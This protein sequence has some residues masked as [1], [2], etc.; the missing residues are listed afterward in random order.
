MKKKL[1]KYIITGIQ[2]LLSIFLCLTLLLATLKVI[3]G[4]HVHRFKPDLM[5]LNPKDWG[6]YVLDVSTPYG[7]FSAKKVYWNNQ[8]LTMKKVRFHTSLSIASLLPLELQNISITFTPDVSASA[9]WGQHHFQA[10]K[11]NPNDD[12]KT[13]ALHIDDQNYLLK[14][15]RDQIEL[16]QE[17]KQAPMLSLKKEGA[18]YDGFLDL[19]FLDGFQGR[20]HWRSDALSKNLYADSIISPACSLQ[21]GRIQQLKYMDLSWHLALNRLKCIDLVDIKTVKG[22][23]SEAMTELHVHSNLGNLHTQTD[24]SGQWHETEPSQ[25]HIESLPKPCL[26]HIDGHRLCLFPD[27]EHLFQASGPFSANTRPWKAML[28]HIGLEGKYDVAVKSDST[29]HPLSIKLSQL[30]GDLD[31]LARVFFMRVRYLIEGGE[32]NLEGSL[33]EMQGEGALHSSQGDISLKL[34]WQSTQEGLNIDLSSPRLH[35]EDGDSHLDADMKLNL[36][37]GSLTRLTGML[38]ILNGQLQIKPISNVETLHEDVQ[39]SGEAAVPRFAVALSIRIQERLAIQGMGINGQLGG[40]LD[41]LADSHIEQSIRG[42]INLNPAQFRVFGREMILDNFQVSWLNQGWNK[43]KIDIVAHR[44]INSN[45]S[46]PLKVELS[47]NGPLDQPHVQLTSNQR[48][49]N[50]LQMLSHLFSRSITSDPKA[51]AAII[52]AMKNNPGQ[53]SLLNLLAMVD[54]IERGL[55]L[56]LFEIGG[57]SESVNTSMPHHLTVGKLL[58]PKLMLKYKMSLDSSARNHIT[59]DY[60]IFPHINLELDTDQEDAGVYLL[61]EH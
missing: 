59:L 19:S 1:M 35:V 30:K 61:Y 10:T 42:E 21:Q 33:D 34:L 58:H 40:W 28:V 45:I 52:D 7:R 44:K 9:Y 53:R 15:Q 43:A 13:W 31:Q 25:W 39:F 6:L 32:I 3:T 5:H 56:D 26:T 46:N 11:L 55:G 57:M 51:D 14:I 41:I 16:T 60:N 12:Y 23:Y 4:L 18:T 29:H 22:I 47:I 27:S 24:S 8:N 36:W 54:R 20:I 17:N 2:W 49:I 38:R 37:V 50:E 48:S